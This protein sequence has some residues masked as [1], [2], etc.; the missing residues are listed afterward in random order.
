MGKNGDQIQRLFSSPAEAFIVQ[1]QGQIDESVI[2]Q[3]RNFATAK[4]YK[5]GK[6]IYFGVID[7]N[8]TNRIIN[9]YPTKFGKKK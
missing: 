9:A 3:M 1:Y 8:D 5:E 2:E 7:E 6:K 4:S